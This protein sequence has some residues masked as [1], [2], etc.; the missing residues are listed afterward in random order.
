MRA[1]CGGWCWTGSS[2]CSR[3]SGRLPRP[4]AFSPDGGTV[5]IGCDSGS[6]VV[7]GADT[8]RTLRTLHGH[9]DRTFAVAYTEKVL[10]TGSADG[11]VRI[12]D[13]ASGA[14]RKVLSGHERWPWPLETDTAGT[15]LATGDAAGTLRLWALPDGEQVHEFPPPGG[16]P[17]R[18]YSI[19]FHRDRV[20]AVYHDG[21]VRIWQLATGAEVGGFQGAAGPVRRVCW[22]P[23]GALLAAGGADAALGLWDPVSSARPLRRS[24]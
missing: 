5:A 1:R 24:W 19:A 3:S 9:R 23:M 22:D 16:V 17:Q 14:I 12:W 21:A 6:V 15:L 2:A 4:L 13:A 18:V 20:A 10:V 11:T 8:G 7:Y